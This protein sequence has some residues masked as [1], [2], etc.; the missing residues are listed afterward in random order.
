M[1][2]LNKLWLLS[3]SC[4]VC[5]LWYRLILAQ[6]KLYWLNTGQFQNIESTDT[7]TDS[8][9]QLIRILSHC[10]RRWRYDFL[11]CRLKTHFTHTQ[12]YHANWL[13]RS[14]DHASRIKWHHT[15]RHWS[16]WL[17]I[18]CRHKTATTPL[19]FSRRQDRKFVQLVWPL[20]HCCSE[21]L[22]S[23]KLETV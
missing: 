15:K 13:L 21:N 8:D 1:G 5:R 6:T 22:T 19:P 7:D 10:V 4:Y 2:I 11:S 14:S 18:G 9:S 16:E 3:R 23:N 12:L 17:K 20:K